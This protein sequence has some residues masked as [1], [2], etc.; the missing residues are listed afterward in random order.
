[1]ACQSTSRWPCLFRIRRQEGFH[2]PPASAR[3]CFG[4]YGRT[5]PPAR[6][7]TRRERRLRFDWSVRSSRTFEPQAARR[8]ADA[9]QLGTRVWI[10]A[11]F[12]S[13]ARMGLSGPSSDA[14]ARAA[15]TRASRI[16][17]AR[18]GALEKGHLGWWKQFWLRS[19]IQVHDRIL[20][21][22]YY[23]ALYAVGCASRPGKPALS[24]FGNFITT[25]DVAWGAI[26]FMNYNEE[27]PY[28]GVFSSNHAELAL[29]Y[30]KM[31]LAQIP[32]EKNR[33]AQAGYKGIAYNRVFSIFTVVAQPPATVPIAPKKNIRMLPADQ[34]SNATFSFLPLINMMNIPATRRSCALSFTRQ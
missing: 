20:E 9:P 21:D 23:G 13:D 34:K 25:D 4:Q 28:Y 32:W 8:R 15:I 3:E 29:P 5:A 1:M 2:P 19:F 24:L 33:T 17:V 10:A 26:Y 27:A 16:S 22:Y 12:E 7:I 18:I 6:W 31:V 30:N 14:L 11:M